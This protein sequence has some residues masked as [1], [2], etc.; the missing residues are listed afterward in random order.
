M[1]AAH[2]DASVTFFDIF[3]RLGL[4]PGRF[5]VTSLSPQNRALVPIL[6]QRAPP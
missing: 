1:N 5:V 2:L 3:E 4:Q 6:A